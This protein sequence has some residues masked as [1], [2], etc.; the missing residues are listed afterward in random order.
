MLSNTTK[1]LALLLI[2]TFLFTG[3]EQKQASKE[4]RTIRLATTTSL[5]NSGL[6]DVLLPAFYRKTGITVQV[7]PMGTGKALRTASD[8][9]CDVVLVHAPQAEKKF[10]TD[11]WGVDRRRIMYNHFVLIGPRD[12]PAGV[13][14]ATSPENAFK[15]IAETKSVFTSRGDNSGTHKKEMIIWGLTGVEPSGSWY[16]SVGTGMGPTLTIANEMRGYVLT[17]YGTFVKFRKKLDLVVLYKSGDAFFNPYSVIMVN[18]A[19]HTH[20]KRDAV[21]EF[22]DFLISPDARELIGNYKVD[23]ELLF[24]PDSGE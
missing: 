4:N 2:C 24:H 22:M 5:E 14:D 1:A 21:S 18:P 16:R 20:V 12:D 7:L 8:G 19:R 23:G 10:I 17:D 3:C 11:G 9:N 15:K 13:K 6:L